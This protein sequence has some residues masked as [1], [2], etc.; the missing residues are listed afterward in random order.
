MAE[1]IPD[2]TTKYDIEDLLQLIHP[3]EILIVSAT[4]DPYTRDAEQVYLAVNDSVGASCSFK[5]FQGVHR[6][7]KE[8]FDFIINGNQGLK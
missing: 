3:R 2:F 1:V 4:S 5:E 6:L 7:D 8:R